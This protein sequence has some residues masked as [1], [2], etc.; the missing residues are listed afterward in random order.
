MHYKY[1]RHEGGWTGLDKSEARSRK[2]FEVIPPP[3][4]EDHP[5]FEEIE[6]KQNCSTDQE[7]P[8]SESLEL[9]MG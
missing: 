6:A 7:I 2:I 8:A 5:L 9:M 3:L 1:I 4:S